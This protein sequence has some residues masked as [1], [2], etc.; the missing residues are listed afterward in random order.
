MGDV[1][2]AQVHKFDP[3]PALWVEDLALLQL[4]LR[5]RSQLWLGYDSWPRNPIYHRVVRAHTH[6]HTHT[7][8]FQV[9]RKYVVT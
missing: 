9:S 7:Q 6:T 3:W 1:L 2:G 8:W 4:Q 5:L